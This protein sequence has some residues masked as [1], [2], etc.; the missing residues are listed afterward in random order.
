[1]RA[2][3]GMA[4]Q[5]LDLFSQ[6]MRRSSQQLQ[7]VLQLL[8]ETRATLQLPNT[9]ITSMM[10]DEDIV[11]VIAERSDHTQ[12]PITAGL[13]PQFPLHSSGQY[14]MPATPMQQSAATLMTPLNQFYD[15]KTGVPYTQET[16]MQRFPLVSALQNS[17]LKTDS[18]QWSR[19]TPHSDT[20]FDAASSSRLVECRS[21]Q[22]TSNE[23]NFTQ[24]TDLK[25]SDADLRVLLQA[26]EF[27]TQSRL[28]F[29]EHE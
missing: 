13:T 24:P 10:C 4:G 12:Q 22:H 16:P 23:T 17:R 3:T 19:T 15:L 20:S 6:Q 7:A 11:R 18:L 9:N 8:A 26:I 2:E 1:M 27:A 14:I 5:K 25:T 29:P 28:H 21:P